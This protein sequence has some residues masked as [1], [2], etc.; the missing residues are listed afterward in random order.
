MTKGIEKNRMDSNM[1]T[2]RNER[3]MSNGIANGRNG[4]ACE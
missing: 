2:T 1:K 3:S 4:S